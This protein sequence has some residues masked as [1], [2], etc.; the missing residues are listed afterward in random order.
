MTKRG[1][2]L[3]EL[4]VAIG[5]VT[6]LGGALLRLLFASFRVYALGQ[7]RSELISVGMSSLG[8][9]TRELREAAAATVTTA[10]DTSWSALSFQGPA[11]AATSALSPYTPRGTFTAYAWNREARTLLR[12]SLKPTGPPRLT[13]AD[14]LNKV[15]S[16]R[17][18]RIVA[19][20]LEAF[21]Y[22][23]TGR[24]VKITLRLRKELPGRH[25]AEETV[26][27]RVLLRNRL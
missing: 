26:S 9:M 8:M 22:E 19:Y 25:F 6:V 17:P 27:E 11:A 12:F 7:T 18:E 24:W 14:L 13:S 2:S 5:L 20:N 10:E 15:K 4:V 23:S 1:W 21:S 16:G 3:L